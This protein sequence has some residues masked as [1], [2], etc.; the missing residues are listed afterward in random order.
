M[1][2]QKHG[3]D[4]FWVTMK[5]LDLML[6]YIYTIHTYIHTSVVFVNACVHNAA[7]KTQTGTHSY[8]QTK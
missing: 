8:R 7:E 3:V 6:M 2:K 1:R 4:M 5:R